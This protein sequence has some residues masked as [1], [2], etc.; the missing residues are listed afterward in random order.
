MPFGLY[1]NVSGTAGSSK[2]FALIEFTTPQ[3]AAA[4]IEQTNGY[5][6]DKNHVFAVNFISQYDKYM[7]VSNHMS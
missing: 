3:E 4:A 7:Q 2:G 1:I 5:K 6:L